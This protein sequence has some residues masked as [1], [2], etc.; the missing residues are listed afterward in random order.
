MPPPLLDKLFKDVVSLYKDIFALL[1]TIRGKGDF[2][3]D[4]GSL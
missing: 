4:Y 1:M 3:T 2:A